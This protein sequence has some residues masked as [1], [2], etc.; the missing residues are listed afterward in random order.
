MMGT[1]L[2]GSRV[3]SS[4]LS[5]MSKMW[6]WQFLL[7]HTSPLITSDLEAKGR[8]NV[9]LPNFLGDFL[10]IHIGGGPV[11]GL[12][13]QRDRVMEIEE[14]GCLTIKDMKL[15]P[16][17]QA[18]TRRRWISESAVVRDPPLQ[19]TCVLHMGSDVAVVRS[20]NPAWCLWSFF[21]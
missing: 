6:L 13:G 14:G 20:G 8:R 12:Q 7:T 16:K 2:S 11:Q 19:R 10:K 9:T 21:V 5:L 3:A 17:T 18:A 4:E 1:S 15:C